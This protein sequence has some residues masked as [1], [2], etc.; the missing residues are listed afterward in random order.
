MFLVIGVS[1]KISLNKINNA[2]ELIMEVERKKAHQ[3]TPIE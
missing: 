3:E 1:G 2:I